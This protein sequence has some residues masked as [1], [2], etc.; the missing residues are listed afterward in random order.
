LETATATRPLTPLETFT[1]HLRAHYHQPDIEA[2]EIV[3]AAVAAHYVDDADPIWLFLEGPPGTGKT[4][5]GLNPLDGLPKV[6]P[7]GDLT[8][9]TFLSGWGAK[10]GKAADSLL[11]QGGDSILF[12]IKD[13]T[14]LMSKKPEA[15]AEIVSQLREIYDGL[16]TKHTGQGRIPTWK[17]KAT[18][19]AAVTNAIER[20]WSLL[21]DLGERFM[22]VR[23]ERGNGLELARRA[24]TRTLS[25]HAVLTQSREMVKEIMKKVPLTGKF[26]R[27]PDNMIGPISHMA[28]FGSLARGQVTRDS[29]GKRTIIDIPDPEAGTRFASA[30]MNAISAYALLQGRVPIT[31]DLRI[32]RRLLFDSVARNRVRILNSVPL[33]APMHAIDIKRMT[34]MPLSTIAWIGEELD[35]LGLLQK[36][37][38]GE[39][40]HF[41]YTELGRS[42]R[43]GMSATASTT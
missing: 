35:A 5:M 32:G 14:T 17:G 39:E 8:P 16:F 29:M 10:N 33:D 25:R 7:L 37:D 40:T 26:P 34:G 3:L 41:E 13:F 1:S 24:I 42:L 19:I 9:N 4:E 6:I 20:Q 12:T 28:E 23:W 21:R 27:L 43:E 15:R 2:I 38:A 11:H 30:I 22:T 36:S 18:V 31:E